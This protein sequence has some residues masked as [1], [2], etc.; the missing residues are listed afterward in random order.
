MAGRI[1]AQVEKDD[2]SCFGKQERDALMPTMPPT[3]E[4]G[5]HNVLQDDEWQH[6]IRQTGALSCQKDSDVIDT[7]I[8]C[9][10]EN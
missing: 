6:E 3:K 2:R 9:R 10:E 4:V 8:S 7:K 5:M 1:P